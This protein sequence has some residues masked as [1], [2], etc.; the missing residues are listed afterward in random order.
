MINIPRAIFELYP[1]VTSTIGDIAYDANGNEVSYDLAAVTTRAEK[2]ACQDKAKEF[3]ATTDWAVLPDVGLKNVNE[4]ITYRK[5]LRG[6]I[7]D[8][9]V[10]PDYPLEPSPIWE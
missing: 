9:Q 8:P 7:I 10:N 5:I 2:D 3:I 1:Q 4:Y 6:F